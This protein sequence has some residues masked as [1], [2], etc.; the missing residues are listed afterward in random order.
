MIPCARRRSRPS[1]LAEAQ[2]RLRH[3][4]RA[5]MMRDHHRGEITV[6]I[7]AGRHHHRRVHAL[8]NVGHA[9]AKAWDRAAAAL[10]NRMAAV[11]ATAI[12]RLGIG[13]APA[14]E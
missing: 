13:W 10:P 5:L 11:S 14:G 4:D 2:L 12:E 8:H 1:F 9:P 7:A 6:G 3:F